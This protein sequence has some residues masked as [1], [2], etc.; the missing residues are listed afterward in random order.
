MLK[1]YSY[2]KLNLF[3][4]VTSKRKDGYHNI[5][6]LITRI[7]LFDYLEVE[8][9]E[10]FCIETN[11]EDLLDHKKNIL[12]VLYRKIKEKY[13]I[14]PCRVVLYKNIP[15]GAG[16]G[17]G[18]SNVATF[19]E[20]LIKL[21][22]LTI[23]TKEKISLLASISADAPFFLHSGHRIIS[24]IGDIVSDE[25]TLPKF[26]IL[27]IKPSF[28]IKTKDIY[29]SGHINITEKL[30]IS[31]VNKIYYSDLIRSLHN[32]LEVAIFCKEPY[33]A[34]IKKL[35][36]KH[37]ADACLVTGSGSALF[38]IFSSQIAL[39]NAYTFFSNNFPD[40]KVYKVINIL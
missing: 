21:N 31:F 10:D 5:Y 29:E 23:S 40:H 24:G 2:A 20:L 36:K 38:G 9:S 6:S 27:L 3:L 17:G 28:S 30:P 37:G 13:N 11:I 26:Y 14:M 32:D 7:N 18:S 25:I 35:I 4:Y 16:L 8:K 22:N 33:L 34:E 15:I 19:L 12:F 1:A 39:M